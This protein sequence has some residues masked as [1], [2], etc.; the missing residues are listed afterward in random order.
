MVFYRL[1]N[2]K[3]LKA[4]DLIRESL[5]EQIERESLLLRR[6]SCRWLS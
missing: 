5:S 1:A 2:P 6:G 4:F 3:M